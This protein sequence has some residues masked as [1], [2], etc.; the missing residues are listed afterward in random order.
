[1]DSLGSHAGE[2]F[3]HLCSII[4][5]CAV[6]L[7]RKSGETMHP[8]ALNLFKNVL[9]ILL[10]IPTVWAFGEVLFYDA[11]IGVYF[12]LLA[13][14]VLGI[15][16][17]DTLFFKSL[18]MMGAGMWAI[19]SC[20]GSPIIITLSI[21]WID[22]SLT[23]WQVIGAV[24]IVAAVLATGLGKSPAGITRRQIAIG[25]ALGITAQLAN[26]VGIVMIKPL[27]GDLPVVFVAFVRLVG[28]F[29][30]VLL[31][32]LLSRDR[33]VILS[34]LRLRRG[35]PYTVAGSFAG[36]Y[37][38][39][40]IWLASMKYTQASIA[41]ALTQTTSVLI[42]LLAVLVLGERAT[43]ARWLGLILAVGGAILVVSF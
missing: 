41:A 43:P 35:W 1:M 3:A 22:E 33:N 2:F 27:L 15:G 24:L 6:I 19:V 9:A 26:A 12:M 17:G 28:G 42:F 18:N 11:P 14:G 10:I 21:V 13:S 29:L 31:V 36:A 25:L 30:G 40:V 39:M 34:D 5:A 8:L 16:V 20:L 38:S 7:F 37:L 4:W 23:A 32:V